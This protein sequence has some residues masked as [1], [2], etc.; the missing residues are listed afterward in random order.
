M[1]KL[2]RMILAALV[3]SAGTAFAAFPDIPAGHWAGD[4]VEEIADLG[5]VIGFP[6]GTFRGNEA[7][8]RYQ[9][10]LVVSRMLA[11]VDANIDANASE[12][13]GMLQ[14]MAAELAAM[15]T[16]AGAAEGAIGDLSSAMAAAQAGTAAD[17][18]A[19]R[20]LLQSMAADMAGMGARVGAAESAIAAISDEVRVNNA[21][22]AALEAAMG[23][24]S[25]ELMR[26]LQNQIA[27]VGATADAA[28]AAAAA[29]ASA[30]ATINDFLVMLRINEIALKGRVAALEAADEA[31]GARVDALESALS[32]RLDVLEARPYF[33]VSGT[34]SIAYM[35]GRTD[36]DYFFDIDRVY[37]VNASR[38]MGNSVFSTGTTPGK[39]AA[40]LVV[41]DRAQDRADITETEGEVKPNLSLSF[42]FVDTKADIV[43]ELVRAYNIDANQGGTAQL[44]Q[45]YVFNLKSF[46]S[47]FKGI[48][49][50]PLTFDFGVELGGKFTNYVG[51]FDK[52]EGYVVTVGAPA[53]LAA[54]NPG[55]VGVYY[56]D[57]DDYIR[58]VRGTLAPAFGGISLKG[59]VSFVQRVDFA[60]D[61]LRTVYGA[62]GTVGLLDLV[63]VSFEY[64]SS[65]L[66]EEGAE[67]DTILWVVAELT[68]DLPILESLKVNYRD[69][70][71]TF[72]GLGNPADL[73]TYNFGLNQTGFGVDAVLDLFIV[74]VTAFYD[75]YQN[76]A[77]TTFSKYGASLKADLFA[78]FS[79][80]AGLTVAADADGPTAVHG[81]VT[82]GYSVGLKHD[83]KAADALIPGLGIDVSYKGDSAVEAF[84]FEKTT[85]SV[86]VNY[87][88][89]VSFLSVTPYV[90]YVMYTDATDE[91]KNW[92]TLTAGTGLS[93]NLSDLIAAPSLAGAVNYR[94]TTHSDFVATE[95]Q[96]SVGLTLNEFLFDSVLAAR[97]GQWNG[98]N[99]AAAV[100]TDTATDISGTRGND[101]NGVEETVFGWEV[102]WTYSGLEFA[103]GMYDSS[104]TGTQGG[105]GDA[106]AQAFS[107]K[108]SVKF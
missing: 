93:V 65:A 39:T 52:K 2:F 83:A 87:D 20:G 100:S 36:G 48:G 74:D 11:V 94:S 42:G 58:G 21:S 44:H 69:T 78:G 29:N 18:A 54:L 1:N 13:R 70:A 35:V 79:L 96:W 19:L 49:G 63:S 75:T 98:T 67:A 22:I 56:L 102:V 108:Y 17:I 45:P 41:G 40:Q 24:M 33:T 53:F 3:I 51:V 57:G 73:K 10:A 23:T 60:E 104:R 91:T 47:T 99:T 32:G 61:V 97:V 106:S 76:A 8:T 59:G 46:T 64:A 16:R 4:A 72:D 50:A 66:N 88:L 34:I 25:E 43:L 28:A 84:G 12:L 5:I 82:T 6:D 27:A 7:F 77:E 62:D 90:G 31:M 103:Y 92:N 81:G 105:T 9:A 95:L 107:I 15:R 38:G 71:V 68:A 14:G 55:L 101:S 85:L 89:S 80:S 26:D 30:I 37:G 86:A